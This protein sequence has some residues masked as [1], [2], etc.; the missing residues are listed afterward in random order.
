MHSIIISSNE[1]GG[2]KTTFTL[3]LLKALM[4]RGYKVQGYKVGPDYIDG[5]FHT[6]ITGN[7]SRNLDAYAERRGEKR[8]Q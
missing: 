4:K 5:D 1:S 3:G 7:T 8:W 6:L 2:G